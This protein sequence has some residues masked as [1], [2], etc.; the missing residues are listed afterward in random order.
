LAR[1]KYRFFQ[2]KKRRT[3][4]Q[5]NQ[6]VRLS[7]IGKAVRQNTIVGMQ[8]ITGQSEYKQNSSDQSNSNYGA[9]LFLRQ[10]WLLVNR[11]Y[12]FGHFRAGF[13]SSKDEY[14]S[15]NYTRETNGWGV[16]IGASPGIAFSVN[17]RFQIETKLNNLFSLDYS[18]S[19]SDVN[20]AGTQ[21]SYD[22]HSYGG[23]INLENAST[24]NIGLRFLASN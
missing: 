13:T 8:L 9:D 17:K 15:S 5:T 6:L 1:R 24:L 4:F 18:Q 22:T 14:T 20:N 23:S 16:G 7:C 2:Y 10:Y 21:S 12:A 3:E 19:N 11:F